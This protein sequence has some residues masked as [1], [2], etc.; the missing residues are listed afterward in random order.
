MWP[1]EESS[2]TDCIWD[3]WL[4]TSAADPIAGAAADA[5][6]S[7]PGDERR[8]QMRAIRSLRRRQP[9]QMA[10]IGHSQSAAR[11]TK[12]QFRHSRGAK[13]AV[14]GLLDRVRPPRGNGGRHERTNEEIQ[15]ARRRNYVQ[16]ARRGRGQMPDMRRTN[17]LTAALRG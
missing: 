10:R 11:A 6:I 12:P 1:L 5:A 13:T 15:K 16:K 7:H 3:C 2:K 9:A 14:A 17:A 4:A 8:R